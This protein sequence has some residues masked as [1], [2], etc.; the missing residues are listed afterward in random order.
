MHLMMLEDPKGVY[1]GVD[2]APQEWSG[3]LT[4]I[5]RELRVPEPAIA[6]ET[7]SKRPTRNRRCNNARLRASG[8]VFKYPSCRDGYAQLI[9][10]TRRPR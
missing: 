5:A 1:I 9:E 10:A 3:L 7:I 4:W 6:Q 8:Y 2:S